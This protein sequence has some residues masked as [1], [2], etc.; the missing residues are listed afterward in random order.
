MS[1][2][3]K[4]RETNEDPLRSRHLIKSNA[5]KMITHVEYPINDEIYHI[6]INT[7]TYTQNKPKDIFIIKCAYKPV[8]AHIG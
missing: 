7:M 2:P 1:I 8:N 5:S 6:I 3:A 4:P